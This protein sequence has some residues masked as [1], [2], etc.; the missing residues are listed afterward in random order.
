MEG[1]LAELLD[2]LEPR[3]EAVSLAGAVLADVWQ[4]RV[5]DQARLVEGHKRRQDELRKQRETLLERIISTQ[6]ASVIKAFEEKIEAIER[7]IADLDENISRRSITDE[8]YGTAVDLV[9]GLLKK[10]IDTWAN[11]GYKGKRLITKLVFVKNPVFDRE[12]GYRTKDL[13]RAIRL[14]QLISGQQ[15]LDVEVGGIEP[16]SESDKESASTTRSSD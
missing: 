5:R 12:V 13:A 7:G 10:P 9:L 3:R 6:S 11:G 8:A 2:D 1:N 16:P 15:L 4:K 14:F